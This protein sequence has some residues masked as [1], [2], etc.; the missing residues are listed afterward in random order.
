MQQKFHQRLFHLATG[1]LRARSA[2]VLASLESGLDGILKAWLLIALLA[3]SAR[4]VAAPAGIENTGAPSVIAY[5]LLILAPVVSTLLA[6]R[7]FERDS[8]GVHLR[9]RLRLSAEA[10]VM[11]LKPYAQLRGMVQY[12]F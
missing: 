11:P 2:A 12:Y 9:D 3:C 6:L 8:I 10:L 1:R 4:A 5:F 7:W